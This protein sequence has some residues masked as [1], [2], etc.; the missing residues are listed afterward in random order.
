VTLF[1]LPRFGANLQQ[2]LDKG[3]II[4]TPDSDSVC[5]RTGFARLARATTDPAKAL[6]D[7]EVIMITVPAMYHTVFWDTLAP[8][9]RDGQ[10]LLFATGYYGA[11][12]HA[13]RAGG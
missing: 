8:H 3:G 4:L 5:G 6:A 13:R 9:L 7:A 10:I 2:I 12:R 1:E 11:L